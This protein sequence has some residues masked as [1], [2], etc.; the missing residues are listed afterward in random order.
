MTTIRQTRDIDEI[1]AWRREVIV[2]VFGENP[3]EALMVANLDYYRRNIPTGCHEAFVAEVD[4]E[5]A[6]CG[7]VCFSEELPSPDNPSGR[8]AYL[9]NIYVREKFRTHGVGHEIVRRLIET[10]RGRGCGKIYLETTAE[11]R[12]L[13]KSVGFKDM[14]DMMKL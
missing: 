3:S 1:M 7:A 9:M 5:G 12:R 13:Y 4:G 2:H 14:K 11:G 10:S 8:C 6:G